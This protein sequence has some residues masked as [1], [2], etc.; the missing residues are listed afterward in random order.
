MVTLWN[1]SPYRSGFLVGSRMSSST[2]SL[3]SS[4]VLKFS[5]SSSTSP[6]RLPRMLVEYQPRMPSIRDLKPGA[7]IVFMSV[8]PVLKSLPLM[9][10]PWS[11]AYWRSAGASTA[12]FGAPLAN[13][14][15]SSS[16]VT[17]AAPSRLVPTQTAITSRSPVFIVTSSPST[18]T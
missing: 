15:P 14:T 3:D 1:T 9:A 8:W 17:A 6:S 12:R 18:L 16:A 13:G 5:G 7:R 10:T 11:V 4:L 2:P